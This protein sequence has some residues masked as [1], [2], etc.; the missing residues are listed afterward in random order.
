M[1]EH[2]PIDDNACVLVRV[3][4]RPSTYQAFARH[5]KELHVDVGDLLSRIA[6]RAVKP[7]PIAP[8]AEPKPQRLR[9]EDLDARIRELNAQGLTDMAISKFIGISQTSTSRRRRLLG[10]ESPRPRTYRAA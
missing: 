9:S 7:A 1:R 4:L 3:N 5:A 10:L 6:D 2:P 8:H